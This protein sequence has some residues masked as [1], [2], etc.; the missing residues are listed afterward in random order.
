MNGTFHDGTN[1]A[2]SSRRRRRNT[3]STLGADYYVKRMGNPL[4]GRTEVGFATSGGRCRCGMP[5]DVQS[6]TRNVSERIKENTQHNDQIFNQ[7]YILVQLWDTRGSEP[8]LP[9]YNCARLQSYNM[10]QFLSLTDKK[11]EKLLTDRNGYHLHRYNNWGMD[12]PQELRGCIDLDVPKRRISA[13]MQRNSTS[14]PQSNTNSTFPRHENSPTSNALFNNIDACMLV[15]DATS[16]TSFL[17][18]VHCHE[19][20]IHRFYSQKME[21]RFQSKRR[22]RR[23]PFIVVANKIDLLDGYD[24]SSSSQM[25]RR[26][27][28]MGFDTYRGI[29]EA[30]EYAA[31]NAPITATKC[32][33][34]HHQPSRNTLSKTKPKKQV[35]NKLTFSLKE[36]AWSSDPHYLQSLQ[37][38]DDQLF[39]NRTMILLWCERNGIQHVEASALDGRGVDLAMEEL[40][41]LG[42]EEKIIGDEFDES[43]EASDDNEFKETQWDDDEIA[44]VG[45]DVHSKSSHG[46]FQTYLDTSK[47]QN[48]GESMHSNN[49]SVTSGQHS[50][51]GESGVTAIHTN[52]TEVDK[53]QYTFLYEPKYETRLD[54]FARYS[55]KE[56]KRCVLNC[57]K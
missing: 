20:C 40:V 15:Y 4:F 12:A 52:S 9:S 47:E 14:S 35:T 48:D 41:K 25:P 29:D 6:S 1:D 8:T 22:R 3:M 24:N 11:R 43:E 57:L 53:S 21:Q 26:R 5:Q 13:I 42:I 44:A 18:L 27:N 10:F 46:N 16:S 19:E 49:F 54:L 28:V 33:N 51:H 37:Q 31:E 56:D 38:A 23:V 45:Y 32:N 36:T 34:P 50:F 55:A 17:R 2:S 39:A 7:K 30:Y